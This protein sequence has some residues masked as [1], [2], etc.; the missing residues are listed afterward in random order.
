MELYTK[1]QMDKAIEFGFYQCK[2]FGD[3]TKGERENFYL[4]LVSC[5]ICKDTG[6]YKKD[7][8]QTFVNKCDCGK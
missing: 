5:K 2:K 7:P 3:I 1:E 6:W 8:N 4:S